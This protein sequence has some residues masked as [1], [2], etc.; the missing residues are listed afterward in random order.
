MTPLRDR[1]VSAVQ[2]QPLSIADL[3]RCL[4]ASW[5]A[6]YRAVQELRDEGTVHYL[7]PAPRGRLAGRPGQRVTV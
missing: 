6:V 7:P 1:V 3:A 4:S 5:R 2:L